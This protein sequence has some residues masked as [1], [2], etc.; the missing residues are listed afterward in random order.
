[1]ANCRI[2]SRTGSL[3]IDT[4][5][6]LRMIFPIDATHVKR[7]VEAELRADLPTRSGGALAEHGDGGITGDEADE[8]ETMIEIPTRTGRWSETA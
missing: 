5:R 2:R 3:R 4:P 1:V 8:A 7:L 6:S